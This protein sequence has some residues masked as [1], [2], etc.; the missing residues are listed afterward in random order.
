M[1][2][3]KTYYQSSLILK[4]FSHVNVKLDTETSYSSLKTCSVVQWSVL[5]SCMRTRKNTSVAFCRT[6]FFN[7]AGT[8]D[9]FKITI[10]FANPFPKYPDMWTPKAQMT[11]TFKAGML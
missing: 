7:L 9:H 6:A 3:K 11:V 5:H 2:F 4:K 8:A 10:N 1:Y